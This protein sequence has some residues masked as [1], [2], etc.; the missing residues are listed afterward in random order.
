MLLCGPYPPNLDFAQLGTSLV[1]KYAIIETKLHTR[2]FAF[3]E[4]R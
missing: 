2:Q 4:T 1:P 3:G